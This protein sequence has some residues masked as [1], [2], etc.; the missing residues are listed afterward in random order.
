M[1]SSTATATATRRILHV[2]CGQ[3][4]KQH[5][6]APFRGDDWEE[7]RFDINAAVRP[8]IVG[9]IT[10]LSMIADGSFD[11]LFSSHNIEHLFAHQVPVA[12]AEFARVLKPGRGIAIVTCPDLQSVGQ[13]IAEGKLHEPLYTSPAGPIAPID[14]VYG[15]RAS[16]ARGDIYMA[17]KTGFT[18]QA[19]VDAMIRAG[20]AASTGLRHRRTYALWACGFRWTP[21]EEERQQ[22]RR[23]V[24]PG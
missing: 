8:D 4:R 19:L 16:V 9:D 23:H 24:F 22:V 20:F 6:P 21:S 10:D 3:K 14:I 11:A 2:G 5:L 1:S 7:V 12:L 18:G 17:H 15:H 13:A